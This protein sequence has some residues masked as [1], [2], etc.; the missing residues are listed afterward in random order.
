MACDRFRLRLVD[1]A[2]PEQVSDVRAK[3]VDLLPIGVQ[4]EGVVLSVGDPEITV[5]PS[6]ELGGLLFQALGEFVVFPDLAREPRG[7]DLGVVGVALELAGCPR[8]T[9]EPPVPV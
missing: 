4:G 2:A 8:E 6:L 3:G 9:R 7:A 5:E 1:D